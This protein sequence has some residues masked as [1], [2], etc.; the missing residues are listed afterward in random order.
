MLSEGRAEAYVVPS[1]RHGSDAR[2]VLFAHAGYVFCHL[3]ITEPKAPNS[4]V[5]VGR[6]N[7]GQSDVE[8]NFRRRG[9]QGHYRPSGRYSLDGS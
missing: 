5:L 7:V 4:R 9:P 3:R 8:L 2:L 6:W 1:I